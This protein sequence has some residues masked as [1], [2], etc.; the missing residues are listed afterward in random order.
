MVIGTVHFR[1]L[2]FSH[3]PT[4]PEHTHDVKSSLQVTP[5]LLTSA[6]SYVSACKNI[7]HKR[8]HMCTGACIYTIYTHTFHNSCHTYRNCWNILDGTCYRL[9]IHIRS[10]RTAWFCT[11]CIVYID[12]ILCVHVGSG[13]MQVT[14]C[15]DL[16]TIED[17]NICCELLCKSSAWCKN[18]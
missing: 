5:F 17:E 7:A 3:I 6:T 1:C 13:L 8:T 12:I 4:H 9:S 14:E 16:T 2:W 18:E 10:R 11:A 15:I